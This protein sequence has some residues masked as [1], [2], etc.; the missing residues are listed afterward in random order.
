[1]NKGYPISGFEQDAIYSTH[2][3]SF[4]AGTRKYAKR[5]INRRFRKS[6]KN[7]NWEE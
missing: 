1:M 6:G 3:L 7:I 2:V 5:A 4:K